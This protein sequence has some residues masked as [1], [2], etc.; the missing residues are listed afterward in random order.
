MLLSPTRCRFIPAGL[1]WLASESPDL[2]LDMAGNPSVCRR[3][4]GTNGLSRSLVC[5]CA[6]GFIGIE[7]CESIASF[8]TQDSVLTSIRGIL[9]FPWGGIE[10]SRAASGVLA[11]VGNVSLICQ[12]PS[13]PFTNEL[14]LDA[15]WRHG[16]PKGAQIGIRVPAETM[17]MPPLDPDLDR[18]VNVKLS[19][20]GLIIILPPEDATASLL[21]RVH[22]TG[23]TS[24]ISLTGRNGNNSMS[25]I[26]FERQTELFS[27]RPMFR[28][29][30]GQA[31]RQRIYYSQGQHRW[32]IGADYDDG[33]VL[34]F[35]E[36]DAEL[37]TLVTGLWVVRNANGVGFS[38]VPAFK[39]LPATTPPPLAP[40]TVMMVNSGFQVPQAFPS[41]LTPVLR[42]EPNRMQEIEINAPNLLLPREV[43]GNPNIYHKIS[44]DLAFVNSPEADADGCEGVAAVGV[45]DGR[46]TIRVLATQAVERCDYLLSATEEE[47]GEVWPN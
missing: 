35:S 26:V 7:A 24:D 1:A 41:S 13:G 20:D 18:P 29:C 19:L 45:V 23:S 4:M 22:V 46:A 17:C 42:A 25:G 11:G 32:Q 40:F 47:T 15:L 5:H 10:E 37:P 12:H 33:N 9:S 16:A 34:A 36:Q 43:A 30:V 39:V 8:A 6:T 28:A 21:F 27:K 38:Q 3:Q 14:R 31:E 44:Y 2:V